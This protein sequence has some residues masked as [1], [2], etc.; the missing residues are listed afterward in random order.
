[1]SVSAEY[2]ASGA[3]A[4]VFVDRK[5]SVVVVVV[6]TAGSFLKG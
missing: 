4:K 5:S 3:A 1:M 6:L 2:T